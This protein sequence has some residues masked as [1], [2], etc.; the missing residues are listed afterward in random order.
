MKK[1]IEKGLSIEEYLKM[2]DDLLEEGKTTGENQTE[3]LFNYAKLNRQRIKRL[4]KTANLNETLAEKAWSF[5]RKMI[6]LII[7]EGW[8]SDAAQNMPVVEKIA[9]ENENIN[10]L[11]ILRDENLELMDQYLTNNTRSIPILIALD[12]NSLEKLGTWGP[13]PKAAADYRAELI[14]EGLEKSEI[15]E[16]IQRWYL[17]NKEQD[18]Q[19]EFEIL[20]SDWEITT[21]SVSV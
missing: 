1:Y 21:E 10:T 8:C 17:N 18:I 12:A 19:N 20:L 16:K 3:S 6:W 2:I 14:T 4:D 9:A 15:S 13:R 11:Y 7:T 5:N